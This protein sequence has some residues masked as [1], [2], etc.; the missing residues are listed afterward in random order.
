MFQ[1]LFAAACRRIVTFCPTARLHKL[2]AY[3]K[4]WFLD[5]T[6]AGH[7][8]YGKKKNKMKD[9]GQQQRPF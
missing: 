9:K 2:Y 6:P 4:T 7:Q 3:K 5:R 1:S 8:S